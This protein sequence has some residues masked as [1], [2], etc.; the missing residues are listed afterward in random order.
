MNEWLSQPVIKSL[1]GFLLWGWHQIAHMI[2]WRKTVAVSKHYM[3]GL[4]VSEALGGQHADVQACLLKIHE[5]GGLGWGSR[6]RIFKGPPRAFAAC[7]RSG[8]KLEHAFP[9]ALI[10]PCCALRTEG[11]GP[12][13]GLVGSM[14][15]AEHSRPAWRTGGGPASNWLCLILPEV[16]EREDRMNTKELWAS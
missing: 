15:R 14:G 4:A 10:L 9:L 8:W 3:L 6:L 12:S 16:M 13:N 11:D 2:G 5:S 1:R 7:M